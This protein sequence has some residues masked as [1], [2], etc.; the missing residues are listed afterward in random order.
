M[1]WLIQS[2]LL[3]LLWTWAAQNCM[4][5]MDQ[6]IEYQEQI[7]REECEKTNCYWY[8]IWIAWFPYDSDANRVANYWYDQSNWNIDMIATFMQEWMFNKDAISKTKDY[9][10][11]QLH[12]NRTNA[13]RIDD[14][15][16]SDIMFQA[17]VCVDKWLAVPDPSKVWHGWKVRGK[18][19]QQ[20]YYFE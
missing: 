14:E 13:K 9:W 4:P 8:T 6:I 11:C 2:L 1:T 18:Y 5:I 15:R 17:E 20:I 10:I 16:W 19:K 12:Y 3:C 7:E